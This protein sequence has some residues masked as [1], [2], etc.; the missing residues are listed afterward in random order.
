MLCSEAALLRQQLDA[1]F[2]T[3]TSAYGTVSGGCCFSSTANMAPQMHRGI[4]STFRVPSMLSPNAQG[5]DC[6][7]RHTALH[8]NSLRILG[9]IADENVMQTLYK[10]KQF[11]HHNAFSKPSLTHMYK[12]V[13]NSTC[14]HKKPS[15]WT[16]P[17]RNKTRGPGE[18]AHTCSV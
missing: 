11:I 4:I 13:G 16:I 12:I 2:L 18:P 3:P 9:Q 14:P 15:L 8:L 17:S 1:Y 5:R 6:Q 7:N 10:R